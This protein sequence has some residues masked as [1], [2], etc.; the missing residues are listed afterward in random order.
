M[1]AHV[2]HT[3]AFEF[4]LVETIS[5]VRIYGDLP[6]ELLYSRYKKCFYDTQLKDQY[7]AT[8]HAPNFDFLTGCREFKRREK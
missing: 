1:Y 7:P 2:F 4:R 6:K 5:I 3:S 8:A